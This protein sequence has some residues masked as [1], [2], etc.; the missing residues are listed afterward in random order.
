MLAGV[1]HQVAEGFGQ[2]LFVAADHRLPVQHQRP[3]RPEGLQLLPGQLD[4][5]ADIAFLKDKLISVRAELFQPQ[6]A[7][8]QRLHPLDLADLLLA[9]GALVHL[10]EQAQ[11]RQG[12]LQL[13]G[14]VRGQVAGPPGLQPEPFLRHLDAV[15]H[16][17]RGVLHL[18]DPVLFQGDRQPAAV[19]RQV[20]LHLPGQL[21]QPVHIKIP[22]DQRRR[23]GQQEDPADHVSDH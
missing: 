14:N 6:Q 16:L 4:Q 23:Q 15:L 7:G 12:R 11:G 17:R 1:L 22:A 2:P 3:V 13:V 20:I 9:V 5:P 8:D 21:F 10:A 19:A 18:G